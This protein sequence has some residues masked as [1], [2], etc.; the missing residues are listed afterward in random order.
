MSQVHSRLGVPIAPRNKSSLWNQV[1]HIKKHCLQN[2]QPVRH[3]VHWRVQP[4]NGGGQFQESADQQLRKVIW[5]KNIYFEDE[6]DEEVSGNN[7]E[8]LYLDRFVAK[9][10]RL[11]ATLRAPTVLASNLFVECSFVAFR[12]GQI[13]SNCDYC[14]CCRWFCCC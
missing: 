8:R 3:R 2:P 14:S 6:L 1:D 11:D 9:D 13:V 4:P 7:E 12:R 5:S 10:R